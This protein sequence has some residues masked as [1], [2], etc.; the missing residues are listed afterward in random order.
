LDGDKDA[1]AVDMHVWSIIMGKNPDKKQVNPKNQAE[2]D[3]AK[4]FINTLATE[5]GLAPR[6]VQA[7]LWAANIMRTGGRPDSYEEYFKKQLDGKGLKERI[8]NWRNEGYKPFSKVR[9]ER[10]AENQP[11][12]K[13]QKP[14]KQA[15]VIVKTGKEAGFSDA[16][17]REYMKRNGYTDRQATD[18]IRAYNDKKEGI[19]I[20]PEWS[21]LRKAAVIFKRRFL[22]SRGLMPSSAFASYEESQANT[23]KD[24]NRAEKTLVDFNRAMKKVPKAD[25]DKVRIDFDEYVRGDNTV[26]LPADLKKVA[27][28]MRAHIDS[29]SISLINSGVVD[30]HL[31][32]KIKDN[33]GSYFTRSYK[34]HDRANWKNEVEEDI[35]QKAINLLK[36]QY[37]KMAE[38]EAAKENMDVEEA[39]DNL[40]TNA[41]ND[42]LTKSGAENFVSGGKKGSK[43]L[44]ILKERQDI[45][46]EIRM[47]MGEYTDPAQNYARTILK[48][49]ALAANHHFLTE[50][51][52]NGTGVFLF[53]KNDPRRPLDFDYKIAAEGSETMNP[54]NGMYTTEEIGKQFEE[55]S[56]QLN[57]A[58]KWMLETYMKVLSSVKWGKTIGSIMTHAKNVFGNLGFVLLNGHWRVNE[59][60]KAYQTVRRDLWSTDNEKSREYMNHLIGLGIVKQSAGIGELRAMFKDADWDTA[61]VERLNKKSSSALEFIKYKIGGRVKKFLEDRYQAEDD[62]FKIVAYENELSRYSKAMFGKRKTELTKEEK[63]EVD[64]VVAE[65]VKNTYPTYSRIPELVNVIRKFPF[66]GNF[67]A[68]QAESYRTAFNT[69]ALSL[70]EIRSKNFKIR[71][72]G[73]QRL[74]GSL[75]YM[76]GKTAILSAFSNA[77]GMGYVG[78]LGY[79]TDDDDE[80]QKENDVRK[81]VA[82]WSKNSDL[83]VLKASNG[84]IRYI[85]FSS[86]DPHGGINKALNSALSGKTTI[87]GFINAIGSTIEP[88]VGE[89]MTTAAILAVK[90]NQDA[91][92]KPIYNPEDTFAQKSKDIIAYMLNVVQPGTVSTMKRIYE[93]ESVLNEVLGASTGMRVYD[94][95]VA[96]N[97]GYS[98]ITYRNR[99]EDAKRIYNSEVYSKDATDKSIADAKKRAENA[100]TQIHKE[101]YE[102]YYSAVR[103]GANEDV[104]FDNIKRFGRMSN[105]DMQFMFG[106]IPYLMEEKYAE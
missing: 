103:L 3:R 5:M 73:A 60:G 46:L 45:P 71:M 96:E 52:K 83:V 79:F 17:I 40:V 65:I 35:K 37:R 62:F 75:T 98:M 14:S 104:L 24:F 63:A 81:F 50:V 39:L 13:K 84:K 77:V 1:I 53:E 82:P 72:I 105:I 32:Q 78:I 11:K 100:I 86:S 90:N 44:S 49:S 15:D 67:I 22:L 64:K 6:E 47:L 8:E 42:M 38:E 30:E 59:M 95:D 94:V 41:V 43:D 9:R 33:L 27:D 80:K 89:E 18:A 29:I 56:S 26:S 20:D 55:Q 12:F 93:S 48:M 91:Y 25:R 85:D 102:R 69:A 68:F 10:E 57:G 74:V 101:I 70:E 4:E 19:F 92:G 54:L 34:V 106:E 66:V 61:M 88:F 21:K 36:V 58:L 99:M 76:A 87:D 97:F 7:A 28:T 51:K 2:F 23:A 31:A 16:G